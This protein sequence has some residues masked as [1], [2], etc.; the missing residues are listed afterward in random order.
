MN[1]NVFLPIILQ[2]AGV[3]VIIAEI[4]IPSGG[5]LA[6]VSLGLIGYS[7]FLVFSSMSAEI[8]FLFLAADIIIIPFLVIAGLKIIAKSPAALRKELSSDQGVTSQDPELINYLGKEGIAITD[9]RP[10]GIAKID[11]KRVDVVS[12]GE[13]LEKDTPVKVYSVTG[14]QIIVMAS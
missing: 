1:E 10:A 4:F 9:L 14:N 13:Y 6:V 11:G 3:V 2:L 12:R 8:G 5:V 7:L